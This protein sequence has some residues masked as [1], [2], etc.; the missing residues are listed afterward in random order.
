[1]Q[2]YITYYLFFDS[3][4]LF[5]YDC[6]LSFLDIIYYSF[7]IVK[8]DSMKNRNDWLKNRTKKICV[9]ILLGCFGRL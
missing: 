2:C 1:M 3:W 5:S 8:N 9:N 6:S 4:R 7:I